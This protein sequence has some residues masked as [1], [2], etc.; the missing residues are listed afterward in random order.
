MAYD[1]GFQG[2]HIFNRGEY[3]PELFKQSI[4]ILGRFGSNVD[5]HAT[6][7]V[8]KATISLAEAGYSLSF[9]SA[10]DTLP[11]SNAASLVKDRINDMV[12]NLFN[13][14]I[15]IKD[16]RDA[17]ALIIRH[18]MD[19]KDYRS[20]DIF[21]ISC[22]RSEGN[23]FSYQL[24]FY[25][26]QTASFCFVILSFI[27]YAERGMVFGIPFFAGSGVSYKIQIFNCAKFHTSTLY[28]YGV[29]KS[30]QFMKSP[31][32]KHAATLS[33]GNFGVDSDWHTNTAGKGASPWK[34][35]LQEDANLVI[36]DGD[37]K[38]TWAS[39]TRIGRFSKPPYRL[40]LQDDGN[41]VIYSKGGRPF[42]SIR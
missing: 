24:T 39:Q 13:E 17:I 4:D 34:L 21:F 30:G 37:G 26:M 23:Y 27:S 41:L 32:G 42:W 7:D 36:Y 5:L 22:E 19:N 12:K 29:L 14:D 18:T 16:G 9:D 8:P 3:P 15:T 11:E 40:E 35:V 31:D 1:I 2:G 33:N 6:V 38:P 20:D 28:N 25:S 10:V